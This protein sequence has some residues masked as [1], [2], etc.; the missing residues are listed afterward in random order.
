MGG[1]PNALRW[2]RRPGHY[3]VYYL[4]LTDPATGV[5][6][7]SRYTMLAPRSPGQAPS[8]SL[9]FLTMDPRA[10]STG[11]SARKTD[12]SIDQLEARSDP[13]ELKIAGAVL[14]DTAMRGAIEDVA[15]DLRWTPADGAYAPVNPLLHRLGLAGTA[16]VVPHADLS[17]DGELTIGG[18]AL[19][20]AGARGG[21]AHVWGSKHARSWAWLH[22]NDLQTL[23]GE[24]VPGAYV[25]GVSATVPR[26]GREIGPNTPFVGRIDGHEFR[27]TSPLRL[28]SNQSTYALSG[29]RF[30]VVGGARK[31]I[32]E[33]S[34]R[35]D[36]LA[37]VTY[38]DPDGELAYCY[39]SE[40]ATVH[41][42]VYERARQVGGWA[43]R[44]TLVAP[45]RAHFEYG[46]RRPVPDVELLI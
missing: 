26:F 12:F 29:W 27:S 6:A 32:G 43:H 1:S 8:C 9:W 2:N 24:P 5:G 28:L 16:F 45:G 19:E 40:T 44:Q 25:E 14:T 38:H 37:G 10:E 3:E 21:Q 4:T 15:W 41:V 20:L 36:Q 33:V 13:F 31:L 17:I 23:D 42:D 18:D 11:L 30:E 7:W 35:R 46:Q 39:N 22:C 34:A